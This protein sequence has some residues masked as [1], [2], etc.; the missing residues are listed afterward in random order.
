MQ[1]VMQAQRTKA[2]VLQQSLKVLEDLGK[3]SG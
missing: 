1:W 3:H 2:Q